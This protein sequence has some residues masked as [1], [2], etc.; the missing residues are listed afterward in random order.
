MWEYINT[1]L[2]AAA[3]VSELRG[4]IPLAIGIYKM[5]A[6]LAFAIAVIGNMIP[7]FFILWLLDPVQKWL[8][9]H[10]RLFERFFNWLFKWTRSRHAR[11]FEL[12]EELALIILVAIPLPMTGA[13]TGSLAAFV[14]GIPYKKALPLIFVGVLIAGVIVTL[15][16]T[17]VIKLFF[18]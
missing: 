15:A 9:T 13:W 16:A 14:F 18:V 6:L 10:S 5:P 4:A 2:L 7:V 3:P 8:S 11:K 1:L 17:G 12:Y